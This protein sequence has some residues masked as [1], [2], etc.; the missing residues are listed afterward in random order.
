MNDREY[1]PLSWLSQANYCLHRAALLLNEHVWEENAETAKGR[2]EHRNVHTQR[3]ERCGNQLKLY[4][5]TV[6]SDTLVLV[7]KCD[8]IEAVHF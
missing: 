6:F 2:A 3:V 5:Y 8:C 7:W 4:E 1:L